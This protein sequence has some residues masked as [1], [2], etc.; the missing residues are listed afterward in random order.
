MLQHYFRDFLS[1]PCL[2]TKE[3]PFD[4]ALFDFSPLPATYPPPTAT[5]LVIPPNEVLGKRVEQLF[6]YYISC[7]PHYTLIAKNIQVFRQKITIGELDFL[8]LDTHTDTVLHVELVYKF[9]I[10]DTTVRHSH[11]LANWIGPNRKDALLEKTEKLLQKQLPLLYKE[12]TRNH[13]ISL[14]IDPS[15]IRQQ[16]CYFAQL[17]PPLSAP[18]Y[19]S[20][21]IHPDAIQGHWISYPTF[22]SAAYH[23]ASYYIPSKKDWICQPTAQTP[24]YSYQIAKELIQAQIDQQKAPMVWIKRPN[25]PPAK[26]FIVW[27]LPH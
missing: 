11:P 22:L 3:V 21:Y 16:V 23:H 14:G 27:W 8:L 19:S 4:F 5:T 6:E 15:M 26:L 13:F 1:S 9:Y 18:S 12:E 2:F 17:F 20:P 7:H 25:T 24:W 10:Y